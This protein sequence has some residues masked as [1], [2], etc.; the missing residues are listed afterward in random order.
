MANCFVFTHR[1]CL[2]NETRLLEISEW[3]RLN[4]E[5]DSVDSPFERLNE[6]TGRQGTFF[7]ACN[8]RVPFCKHVA[9]FEGRFY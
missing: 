8:L 3:K 7:A 6:S 9:N 4:K 1:I 2:V 5:L